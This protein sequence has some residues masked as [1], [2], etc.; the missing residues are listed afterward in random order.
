MLKIIPQMVAK[1][2][3][4]CLKIDETKTYSK[5]VDLNPTVSVITL[6]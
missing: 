5:M 3:K 2:K 4:K 6:N 1:R